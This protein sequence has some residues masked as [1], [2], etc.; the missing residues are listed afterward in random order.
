MKRAIL[1]LLALSM[2]LSLT[3]C[4]KKTAGSSESAS[5]SASDAVPGSSVTAGAADTSDSTSAGKSTDLAAP[6]RLPKYPGGKISRLPS[7]TDRNVE[8]EALIAKTWNI[9]EDDRSRMF[10][11]YDRV[12]L[13]GD[14]KKELFAVVIGDYTSGENGDSGLIASVSEDGSLKLK[15]TFTGVRVPVVVSDHRTNGWNDLVFR[16]Y[17]SDKNV[18]YRMVRADKDGSYS[19]VG[20]GRKVNDL[21]GI[22][23]VSVV[24]NDL[25]ADQASGTALFLQ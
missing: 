15:R 8:L 14:G 4:K 9:P 17:G 19:D 20:K 23:G 1:I 21:S 6:D 3:A 2:A 12:D 18:T 5:A 13:N 16:Q 22:S 11:E 25:G 10:Y 7:E 24:Y